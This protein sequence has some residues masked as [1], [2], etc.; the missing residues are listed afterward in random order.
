MSTLSVC[1][2]IVLFAQMSAALSLRV[3]HRYSK[4]GT[5]KADVININVYTHMRHIQITFVIH[6]QV[7]LHMVMVSCAHSVSVCGERAIVSAVPNQEQL[8]YGIVS[9]G[10]NVCN[11]LSPCILS[12]E[13]V[14]A[15]E[16]PT[17]LRSITDRAATTLLWTELFRG[18]AYCDFLP[19][20]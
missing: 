18:H 16:L 7:H 13:Y 6:L 8:I 3:L 1:F 14:N 15:Q 5:T 19:D 4:P 10:T 20:S 2:N 9:A 12:V 17:D 11:H